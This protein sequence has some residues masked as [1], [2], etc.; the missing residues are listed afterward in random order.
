MLMTVED[1]ERESQ[2]SRFTW[3][4]W[5]RERRLPMVRLGRRVRVEREDF[6]RFMAQNKT[7]A[8]EQ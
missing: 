7:P 3:R 8:R 6:L 1:L 4:T 2:V 5:L